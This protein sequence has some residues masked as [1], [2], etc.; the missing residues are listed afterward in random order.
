MTNHFY[1]KK[2]R[3][4]QQIEKKYP[5]P[6]ATSDNNSA[7]FRVSYLIPEKPALEFIKAVHKV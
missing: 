3:V 2:N 4:V 1:L 6:V 5:N 7:T